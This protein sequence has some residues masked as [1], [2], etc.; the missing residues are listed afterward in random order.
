IWVERPEARRAIEEVA[1]AVG[2][3]LLLGPETARLEIVEDRGWEGQRL[4]LQTAE[5]RY[6]LSLL[7]GGYHQAKNAALAVLGAEILAGRGWERLDHEAIVAGAGG[8]RWPGRLERVDLPGGRSVLLDV[9]H[10]PDG[11]EALARFLDRRELTYDLLFG[12][13]ADKDVGEILPVLA[14]KAR[15]VTLTSP[16]SHRA[17]PPEEIE[18]LLPAGRVDVVP[19]APPALD[20]ALAGDPELLVVCGSVYLVGEIR[21]LLRERFGAPSPAVSDLGDSHQRAS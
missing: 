14:A 18:R 13:L 2:A 19:A 12:V 9:A 4:N 15:R 6:Q 7:L 10:N 11:A 21:E 16:H 1:A 5:N 8:S 3:D 20:S 17:L